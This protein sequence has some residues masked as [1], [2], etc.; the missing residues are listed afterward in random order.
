MVV[1]EHLTKRG[2]CVRSPKHDTSTTIACCVSAK[3]ENED[4]AQ[5]RT[6]RRHQAD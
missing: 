1:K 6:M 2:R 3:L 4:P 5:V